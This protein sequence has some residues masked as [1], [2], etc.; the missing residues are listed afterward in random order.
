VLKVFVFNQIHWETKCTLPSH[1]PLLPQD[2]A[3]NISI[4]RRKYIQGSNIFAS[5]NRIII[6]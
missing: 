4:K 2:S 3:K 6:P 1:Y 5:I